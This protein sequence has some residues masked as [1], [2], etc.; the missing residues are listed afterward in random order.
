VGVAVGVG[1]EMGAAVGVA[2]GV[3]VEMEAAVGAPVG[4]GVAVEVLLRLLPQPAASTATVRHIKAAETDE[5]PVIMAAHFSWYTTTSV[6]ATR[7]PRP[8]SFT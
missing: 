2:V 5:R 8:C 4:V 7:A 1:V 3:G 6:G